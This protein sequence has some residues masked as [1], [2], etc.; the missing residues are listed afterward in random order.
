MSMSR[1]LTA[2]QLNYAIQCRSRWYTLENK[3]QKTN[4]EQTLRK[5]NTTQKNQT[6]Q[7]TPKQN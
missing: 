3:G 2:H 1:F 6:T 4:Q 7:N 5:L